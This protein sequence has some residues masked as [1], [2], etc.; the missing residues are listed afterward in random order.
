MSEIEHDS[1]EF[2]ELLKAKAPELMQHVEAGNIELAVNV[3]EQLQQARMPDIGSD[4]DLVSALK[5]KALVLHDKIEDG[6]LEEAMTTLQEMQTVR[7]RGLYQE[8]GKL[9]RALHSAIT[10]FH[11]DGDDEVDHN[12]ITNMSEATDRLS[13][14]MKLTDRAANKTLD[15][16]EDSLPVADALKDEASS[17]K[18]E[19]ERLVQREMTPDEFRGLYWRLD[20]FFKRLDD[21]TQKL[22]GN[23]T[24]ILMAQDFQDL[25]GQVIT[26]VTG[27]VKEVETSLVDLVFMASQV[28]QITGMVTK[29]EESKSMVDK[30]MKGHGPQI[31]SENDEEVMGSQDDVDDLLSSLGF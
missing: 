9:T 17:L 1:N 22:S 18:A 24:E 15:L 10:N 26:K 16:V 5:E 3:L 25:T 27:L 7:D 2:E 20:E 4:Y 29:G 28:E 31:N 11:I 6:E 21:D 30:D 19:W 14:V 12:D 23:M 13:Y 8:V